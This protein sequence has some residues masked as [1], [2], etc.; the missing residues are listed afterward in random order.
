MSDNHAG[1]GLSA[2]AAALP[3]VFYLIV[4]WWMDRYERE[5]WWLVLL[6]F[7]YGAIGAIILGIVLSLAVIMMANKGDDFSFGTL[8]AATGRSS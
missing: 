1:L 3:V 4:I 6:T 5:P 7:I 2:F 8:L